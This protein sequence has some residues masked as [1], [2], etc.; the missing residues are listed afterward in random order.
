MI[1]TNFDYLVNSIY[2]LNYFFPCGIVIFAEKRAKVQKELDEIEEQFKQEC[3]FNGEDIKQE[4][5]EADAQVAEEITEG[6]AS[7][8]GEVGEKTTNGDDAV[9]PTVHT[10]ADLKET[11]SDHTRKG[12]SSLSTE[13]DSTEKKEENERHAEKGAVNGNGVSTENETETVIEEP[14]TDKDFEPMYE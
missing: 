13:V 11:M 10:K 4:I 12:S 3:V 8:E 5:E 6:E 7:L 1:N 2:Q 9:V 14:T